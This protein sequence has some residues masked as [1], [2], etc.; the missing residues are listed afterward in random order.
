MTR[1]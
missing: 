1:F